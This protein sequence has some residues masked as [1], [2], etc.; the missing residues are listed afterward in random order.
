MFNALF[1]VRR[2]WAVMLK[3]FIQ[4]RRDRLT[5]AMMIG[6]PVIQLTL[7]GFAING[8]PKHLPT[9]VVAHDAGT[10]SRSLVRAME[11]SG[12]FH[13]LRSDASDR[14][15]NRMLERGEAQFALTIPPDFSRALIRGDRPVLLLEADAT[16]PSATGNALGALAELGNTALRHDLVGPLAYLAPGSGPPFELRTHRRYNPDGLTQYNI[17]PGLLGV[18]LTMTMIM[19]TAL[20]ITREVERGTMENLLAT[21]IRPLEV[22]IGKISP[23][24]IIG[25]VQV[26]V[27]LVLARFIFGVPFIGSMALLMLCILAFIAA[28]LTVGITISSVARNQTQAMQ[29]TFFFFLPSMLLSGFMFPFR[30]M[31]GWAQTIGEVLPLTHFLRLI[32]GIMLKGNGLTEAW[33]NLWPLLLFCTIVMVIGVSR[34]RKTLD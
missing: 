7:F 11:N 34:Y 26:A 27:V 22:M 25:Y 21:P 16:D 15:A 10:F 1:D 17:V 18:I 24:V 14:E 9:V 2:L 13:I 8:D 12:Y 19:M 31:P 33:S 5:F 4:L 20:G 32:R 30:G 29:M 28:N 6:L 23:Y 3:E